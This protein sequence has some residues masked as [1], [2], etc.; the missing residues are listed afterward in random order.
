MGSQGSERSVGKRQIELLTPVCM[1]VGT[2]LW[3][4]LQGLVGRLSLDRQSCVTVARLLYIPEP[5]MSQSRPKP[6]VCFQCDQLML[7][8]SQRCPDWVSI[9]LFLFTQSQQVG[10]GCELWGS[11]TCSQ[12]LDNH[13]LAPLG[14]SG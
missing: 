6:W 9:A 8:L 14:L 1:P 5:Y 13:T 12:D 11:S 4:S 2:G 7:T 10:E 3:A